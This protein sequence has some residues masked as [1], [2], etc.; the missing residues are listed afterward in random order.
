MPKRIKLNDEFL[1]GGAICSYQ[2]EGAWNVDGKGY[3]I[4]DNFSHNSDHNINNVSGDDAVNFFYNY[5]EDIK[6]LS[7]GGQNSFRFSISWTRILPEGYGE[8]NRKGV[9]FYNKVIDT[10]LKYGIKPNVTILHYDYPQVFETEFGGW[11]DRKMIDYYLKYAEICFREFGDRVKIWTTINEPKFFS[12]CG[13]LM[14]NWPPHQR[15]DLESYFRTIYN[16]M[17]GSAKAVKLYRD[18]NMDGTIGIVHDSGKVTLDKNVKNKSYVFDHAQL[19]YNSCVLDM[20]CLGKIPRNL[21]LFLTESGLN[22]DFIR[23]EDEEILK[24]GI[25]DFIGLNSYQPYI[26]TDFEGDES[27]ITH[28]NKGKSSKEKEW[29]AIKGWFSASSPDEGLLNDWGRVTIPESIYDVIEDTSQRYPSFPII[30]TENGSAHYDNA[31]D[32]GYVEDDDRI[33][34]LD[35]FVDNVL[36]ARADGYDV[37]GYH[38]WSAIDVWSWVNGY[39]KRYG[40]IRVD[41][42]N[43]YKRTPKKSYYWYKEKIEK[44]K[45][46]L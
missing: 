23:Y 25:V 22:V 2:A 19:F 30:I 8:V 12:Y 33:R 21:E 13:Y 27:V 42:K 15:L 37:Q 20:C 45:I 32:S 44:N 18:L 14:G 36:R 24:E 6:L 17:I 10:C 35:A 34:I 46:K 29:H 16:Q 3:S 9:E 11:K 40:L 39:V 38:V 41:E 43:N 31:D 28:N 5:E 1:W 7:E 4:W 26:V